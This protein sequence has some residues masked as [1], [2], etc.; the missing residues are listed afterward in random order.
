MSIKKII[1]TLR[2][3]RDVTIAIAG[4]TITAHPA[5][6]DDIQAVIP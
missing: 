3:L 5:I 6:P 1:Q 2:P 4:Q